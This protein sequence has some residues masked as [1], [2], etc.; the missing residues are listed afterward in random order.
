MA[1]VF[2]LGNY[3]FLYKHPWHCSRYCSAWDTQL[4]L[5][6]LDLESLWFIFQILTAILLLR[7]GNTKSGGDIMHKKYTD[8]TNEWSKQQQ[9]LKE[10]IKKMSDKTTENTDK[11]HN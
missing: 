5:P 8:R 6:A 3:S 1:P 7:V 10:Y 9:I 11:K 2:Y 4:P